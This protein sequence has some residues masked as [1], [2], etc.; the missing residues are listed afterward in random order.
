MK[1]PPIPDKEP[2]ASCPLF[3]AAIEHLEKA[4]ETN[5]KLRDIIEQH[6]QLAEYWESRCD[7]LQ[8]DLD[9]YVDENETLKEE[10][11]VL[12]KRIEALENP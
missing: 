6:R 2:S 7:E 5:A 9:S 3:D 11:R 10:I 4:R 1:K 8:S 12:T